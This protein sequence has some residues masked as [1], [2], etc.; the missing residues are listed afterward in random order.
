MKYLPFVLILVLATFA[1]S[2]S[3]DVNVKV[4]SF[5]DS[6]AYS[7][8]ADIGTNLLRDSMMLN[9]DIMSGAI[10]DVMEGKE[11][12]INEGERQNIMRS[13]SMK[14]REKQQA[15]AELEATENAKAGKD[16]LEQN[17]SKE[18]VL[19]TE[20]GLQYKVIK[21]GTGAKPTAS[22]KVKVIY[23]GKFIDGTQFDS[24]VGTPDDKIVP[25]ALNR[26][27]KGWTEGLAL[28]K[29]GAKYELYIPFEL[30]Y[31][32]AGRQPSIPPSATLIFEVELLDI[33]KE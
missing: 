9:I 30:A 3:N 31:G 28:M 26:V 10:K 17:K 25:F 22:D 6:V 32:A 27:I 5:E 19:T 21:E 2:S 33:I 20:S 7:I 1:C 13:F 12:K 16:F 15:K 29:V 23:A 18:G 4:V 8:G 24:N 11:V 14:L